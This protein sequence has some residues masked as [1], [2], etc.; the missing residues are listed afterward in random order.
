MELYKNSYLIFAITLTFAISN[1]SVHATEAAGFSIDLIHRDSLQS[2]SLLSPFDRVEAALQRS[3]NR[4]K[5]LIIPSDHHSP[6]SASTEIVPDTGEYLMRFA[7]GTP[8]V[9]TLAVVD[10]GSDLTWI[11]CVP[12][13]GCNKKNSPLFN[14]TRSSTYKSVPCRSDI[15]NVVKNTNCEGTNGGCGFVLRYADNSVSI[16]DLALETL[17]FGQSA[18]FSYMVVGCSHMT[19]GSFSPSTSGIVGLGGGRESLVRQMGP[20]IGGRF[21]YCLQV[22][23]SSGKKASKMHFGDRAVVSG[24]GAV[25][26][27]IVLKNTGSLYY[28]TLLGMSVGNKR[29]NLESSMSIL[30][31]NIV[32]DSGTTLTFLPRDVYSKVEVELKRRVSLKQIDDPHKAMKLCYDVT[33][34]KDVD[35]KIPEI[36]VHFKGADVKL[37]RHNAFIMT[38]KKS[39]IMAS[40]KVM[41]LAFAPADVVPI[42]GNI[43]QMNFLVGYDLVRKTVSFEPTDCTTPIY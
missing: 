24:A 36:T 35:A 16:G 28:L 7:I 5:T 14:P 23:S 21:S 25:T 32:I 9:E 15:C 33:N 26:T 1:P 13:K 43:A 18:P 10:T 40:K 17:S 6:Q 27:P 19:R 30:G 4:S 3:F 8:K 41:C 31:G 2:P 22:P 38:V 11:Q 37:K 12:C 29:F 34:A 39:F 20:S 42:Y